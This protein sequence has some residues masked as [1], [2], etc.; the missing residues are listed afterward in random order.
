MDFLFKC[1][2]KD[3]DGNFRKLVRMKEELVLESPAVPRLL[4]FRLKRVRNRGARP[5][6]RIFGYANGKRDFIGCCKSDAPDVAAELVRISFYDGD[7]VRTVFAD[8]FRHL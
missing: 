4:G 5:E 3:F 2:P 8:D 1:T 7:G 6:K